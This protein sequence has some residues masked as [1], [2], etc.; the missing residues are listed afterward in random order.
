LKRKVRELDKLTCGERYKKFEDVYKI[1]SENY[2][3]QG[4]GAVQ[5]SQLLEGGLHGF[6]G[7]LHDPHTVYFDKQENDDFSKDLK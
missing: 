2:Y 3:T 4:T 7:G 1:L 5:F 6:V